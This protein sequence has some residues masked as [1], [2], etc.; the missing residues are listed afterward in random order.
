MSERTGIRT[1][2]EDE[3]TQGGARYFTEGKANV[4][5]MP[6]RNRCKHAVVQCM[7]EA[8][9]RRPRWLD[10]EDGALRPLVPEEWFDWPF[11]VREEWC[12]ACER[13]CDLVRDRIGWPEG[14]DKADG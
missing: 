7:L 9:H 1:L 5:A 6:L 10:T 3:L 8:G 11:H 13:A 4:A 12:R 2:G 14:E